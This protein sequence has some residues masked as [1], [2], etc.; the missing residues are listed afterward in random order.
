MTK[1]YFEG[2]SNLKENAAGAR[3]AKDIATNGIEDAERRARYCSKLEHKVGELEAENRVLKAENKELRELKNDFDEFK[4]DVKEL[5]R[6][7]ENQVSKNS[8]DT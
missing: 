1:I 4:R 3:L 7:V 2:L 6:R 8:A 5:V